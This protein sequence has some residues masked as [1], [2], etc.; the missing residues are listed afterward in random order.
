ML[1]PP[2]F[3]Q[4]SSVGADDLQKFASLDLV[5]FNVQTAHELMTMAYDVRLCERYSS[6]R[7]IQKQQAEIGCLKKEA[8]IFCYIP[9]AVVQLLN[10]NEFLCFFVFAFLVSC[11]PK[12]KSLRTWSHHGPTSSR[13]PKRP[14]STTARQS[15]AQATKSLATPPMARA[16]EIEVPSCYNQGEIS[17]NFEM[18]INI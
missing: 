1:T 2:H 14:R 6:T 15:P 3:I 12:K 7:N 8:P 18:K 5:G 17:E 13:A 9:F 11:P 4:P 10:P 16:S